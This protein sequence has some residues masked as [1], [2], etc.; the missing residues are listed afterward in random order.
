MG[1]VTRSAPV[2]AFVLLAFALFVPNLV[3]ANLRVEPVLEDPLTGIL[4]LISVNFPTNLFLISLSIYIAFCLM[5]RKLGDIAEDPHDLLA[6]TVVASILVSIAGGVIDFMFLYERAEDRYLLQDFSAALLL[7]AVVLI[8]VTIA[9][10]LFAIVNVRATVVLVLAA[11]IASLSPVSWWFTS[12]FLGS[13]YSVCLLFQIV[14]VAA[15]SLFVLRMLYVRHVL[16]FSGAAE[17]T[18]ECGEP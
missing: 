2:V 12:W 5:G 13:W 9:L 6:S 8:F 10:F 18:Y 1:G 3:A 4:I 15:L 7:P 16:V 17:K 14:L 11:A